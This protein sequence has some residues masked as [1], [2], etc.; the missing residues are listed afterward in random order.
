[1]Q[2]TARFG[3]AGLSRVVLIGAAATIVLGI[4]AAVGFEK[5]TIAIALFAFALVPILVYIALRN[6]ILFPFAIYPLLI[7]VDP[8]LKTWGGIGSIYGRSIGI[9]MILT[10][11]LHAYRMRRLNA[12]P[13]CWYFWAAYMLWALL[14]WM[15]TPYPADVAEA[16]GISGSLFALFTATA[17]YPI[18]PRDYT[19]AR[20][21]IVFAG[22][23]MSAYGF[24][25]FLQGQRM[26]GSTRLALSIGTYQLDP[27]HYAAFFC[28]P[29]GILVARVYCTSG[30]D[31]IIA[32]LL[33]VP[34]FAN[35]LLTGSRGGLIASGVIFVYLG[36]RTRRF[37]L[38]GTVLAVGLAFT[39]VLPNVWSR[40]NDP[41]Q[42]DAS[43]RADIWNTG[44]V[45]IETNGLI[46]TG[47]GSFVDEYDDNLHNSIQKMFAGDHR[48]AHSILI[49]TLVDLGL[50]G[51]IFLFAAWW[52]T[53]RQNARVPRTSMYYSDAIGWESAI[54]G[55]FISA[56]TIDLMLFKY[57]WLAFMMS[58]MLSN[59]VRPRVLLGRPPVLARRPRP[60]LTSP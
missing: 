31:R 60:A 48:P 4:A 22:L 57:P 11:L 2:Q 40:F 42:G 18:S 19:Y 43:G 10:M 39:F 56:L 36:I 6:P 13:S 46:G 14:G 8:L 59:V 21:A 44:I 35:V 12:P 7:P 30:R 9:L 23:A 27:N 55:I 15:W 58:V 51:L 3:S 38:L 52:S 45:A 28:I 20:R 53:A 1:M 47:F 49:Q 25:G 34:M 17:L 41:T 5:T 50:P 33:L 16:L 24:Y 26:A 37:V 32:G 54:I 29:I